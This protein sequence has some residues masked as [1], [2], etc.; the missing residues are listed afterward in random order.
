MK[1]VISLALCL[2]LVLS[3]ATTVFAAEGDYTIT[4]TNSD[5][6]S[7]AGHTYEAYQIF[8]GK[9]DST[10]TILTEIEWGI[11]LAANADAFVAALKEDTTLGVGEANI[12]YNAK[13]ADEVAEVLAKPANHT[14]TVMKAVGKAATAKVSGAPVSA[15]TE[16]DAPYTITIPAD[17]SGYYLVKDVESVLEGEENKDISDFILQVVGDVTVEHKGSIPT[18]DKTVSETGNTYGDAIATGIGETH[19]YRIVAELP[20]D[21][22]LYDTYYLEFSDMM[23]KE[24]D[25]I[26]IVAVKAIIRSSGATV[27]ISSDDYDVFRETIADTATVAPGGTHLRVVIENLKAAEATSTE[28]NARTPI[29]LTADD[30]IELIYTAKV[31]DKALVDGNGIPNNAS[32]IYSNNPNSEGKGESATDETNVYPINLELVK[33]DGKDK[34]VKLKDAEFILSRLHSDGVE[35][36]SEYAVVDSD[37]KVTKWAHHYEGDDCEAENVEHA[38]AVEDNE[39]GSILKTDDNGEI[40]VKGLDTGRYDII[41]IKAPDGYNKLTENITVTTNITIDE[42]NDVINEMTGTTNQGSISFTPNSATVTL[43]VDNY[44]GDVLPSTGGIGTTLFYVLG[45]LLFA[46]AAVVLITKKRM[47]AE[48]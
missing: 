24:L 20:D 14:S 27:T 36:H 22:R 1:R 16:P 15:S 44:K 38:E 2:M 35:Q 48:G 3:L 39:L 37:G 42:A 33:V 28:P 43:T 17:Q 23:S 29:V 31:N 41:E 13:T 32:I 9:L 21:Y 12:F 10:G 11:N 7:S 45:G 8:S 4:I 5:S 26:E 30:A 40:N 46:S 19:Y 25:F 34:T 6:I 18:M 47:G